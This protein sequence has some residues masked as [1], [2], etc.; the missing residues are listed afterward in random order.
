MDNKGV[1]LMSTAT[2][3]RIQANLDTNFLK[4]IAI[5]CMTFDH[6]GKV[7]FPDVLIFQI[8]G[9]IAFPIFAYCIVVGCLYTKDLK[10][11]IFRLSM[12][13]IISQPFYILAHYPHLNDFIEQFG[14]LNI[15]FTLIIGVIAV[16]SLKHKKWIVFA[17]TILIVSV[18]NFDYGINGIMLM[19]IFYIFRNKPIYSILFGT[20]LLA[21]PFLY[22]STEGINIFGRIFDI[23]GFSVLALIFIYSKTDFKPKIN[24]YFFYAYYPLHLFAIYLVRLIL[25]I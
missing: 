12:F 8:I 3:A 15:F 6:V 11:Y 14:T 10:K 1:I 20:A 9:R 17:A 7:F 23:Q 13:A 16:A 21:S 18:F 5:I 4:L 19:L 22:E 24:K 2:K 25:R